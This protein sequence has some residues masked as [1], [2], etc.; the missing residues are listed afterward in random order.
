MIFKLVGDNLSTARGPSR[1]CKNSP[2]PLAAFG[3]L[4][5][6]QYV[7]GIYCALGK[8][9]G[10]PA[11]ACGDK[12]SLARSPFAARVEDRTRRMPYRNA[13]VFAERAEDT[14]AAQQAAPAPPKC[15]APPLASRRSFQALLQVMTSIKRKHYVR[16]RLRSDISSSSLPP[17]STS[18]L[19]LP[20][21]PSCPAGPAG[22]AAWHCCCCCC[23]LRSM[24]PQFPPAAEGMVA[25][26]PIAS[27]M[28]ANP[29][30]NG[31]PAGGHQGQAQQRVGLV[32]R[33]KR[34]S[35]WVGLAVIRPAAGGV[36]R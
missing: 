27:S 16:R 26:T 30:R 13:H 9:S 17:P 8:A 14:M 15:R 33:E 23:C 18:P 4:W 6:F 7:P 24:V 10:V 32:E 21:P 28:R 11:A 2:V 35:A 1:P 34:S 25:A 29:N 20:S 31:A 22:G 12:D 5:P 19:G 36:Y 3:Y